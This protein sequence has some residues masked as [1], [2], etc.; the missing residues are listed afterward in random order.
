MK[1]F[2]TFILIT[3]VPSLVF[4]QERLSIP[5]HSDNEMFFLTQDNSLVAVDLLPDTQYFGDLNK[6]RKD[7]ER[8]VKVPTSTLTVFGLYPGITI[9][10]IN[11]SQE[12]K[13]S[14]YTLGKDFF[15]LLRMKDF[16]HGDEEGKEVPLWNKFNVLL[17]DKPEEHKQ[18]LKKTEEKELKGEEWITGF[19]YAGKELTIKE[20][21]PETV[22]L[23]KINKS[24]PFF[25]DNRTVSPNGD[26][27]SAS[28]NG[29]SLVIQIDRKS[30]YPVTI[31]IKIKGKYQF[32]ISNTRGLYAKVVSDDGNSL[33]VGNWIQG[34][35]SIFFNDTTPPQVGCYNLMIF[36]KSKV[37]K[38]EFECRGR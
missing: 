3:I 25:K 19:A 35:K 26:F 1:L 2:F 7:M 30:S 11:L 36:E 31:Y 22:A 37:S 27:K 23:D 17:S 32:L 15:G 16:H 9:Q 8:I 28:V 18:L 21:S 13:K 6:S 5:K 38:V 24:H 33:L 20:G 34:A 14:T 10:N 12:G 4:G 29:Y